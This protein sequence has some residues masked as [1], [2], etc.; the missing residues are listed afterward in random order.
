MLLASRPS[1]TARAS[2]SARIVFSTAARSHRDSCS[3]GRTRH[4]SADRT[5]I[6]DSLDHFGPEARRL[7]EPRTEELRCTLESLAIQ[8]ETPEPDAL[9]P[10][11]RSDDELEV[12]GAV[13]DICEGGGDGAVEACG[14]A[15]EILS[16]TN[17]KAEDRCCGKGEVYKG[18]DTQRG[19]T[20]DHCQQGEVRVRWCIATIPVPVPGTAVA[21]GVGAIGRNLV[22]D[23]RLLA[24]A[25]AI[26]HIF[27]EEDRRM[28]AFVF[29]FKDLLPGLEE[30][31]PEHLPVPFQHKLV[32]LSRTLGVLL[33]LHSRRGVKDGESGVYVP[34]VCVDPM[35]DVHLYRF[36]SADVVPVLPR[37]RCLARP[38]SPHAKGSSK[39]KFFCQRKGSCGKN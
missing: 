34:L 37:I 22:L 23:L 39:F 38:R 21:R 12:V 20:V 27:A 35:G 30:A 17:P 25:E 1:A 7:A 31:L 8:L 32:Q 19:P 11:T 13:A 18:V 36:D 2:T 15:K 14:G 29:T 26:K 24:K 3:R 5:T 33:N 28:T 6:Q 10:P 16:D 9:A 4:R